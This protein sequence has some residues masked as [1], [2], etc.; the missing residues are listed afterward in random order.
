M[1]KKVLTIGSLVGV[2]SFASIGHSQALPTATARGALQ[3][4]V[5][6][7]Y[8]EPDYGQKA[9]QGVTIFGDFDFRVHLGAEAEYHY[10]ALE[11]P[12]DLAENSFLIGPRFILPRGR[13]SM[14]GK[15]LFGTGS[16]V[17][18]EVQDNPEGGAGTYFAYAVGGGVDYRITRHLVA[19]GDFEYQHWS[20]LT[21]LTPSAFTVG[22][23]YRFR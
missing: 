1:L 19:R 8:A 16:I 12:T 23:A 4:G 21:G 2:L 18:Q 11:T 17:I 3:A 9:I 20:Y 6:W 10:I 22:A 15:V 7:T 14:Y 13:L 5:G